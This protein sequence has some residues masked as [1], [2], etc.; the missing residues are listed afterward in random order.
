MGRKRKIEEQEQSI[1]RETETESPPIQTSIATEN[2]SNKHKLLRTEKT[3]ES[4]VE[5]IKIKV[6]LGD[7]EDQKSSEDSKSENVKRKYTHQSVI[8]DCIYL[9]TK[10]VV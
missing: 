7:D 8:T 5:E 6:L 2:G 10:F 3:G 4:G 1:Q 9:L